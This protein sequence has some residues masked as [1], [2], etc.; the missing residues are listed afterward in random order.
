MR[1]FRAR[2]VFVDAAQTLV[3]PTG[4]PSGSNTQQTGIAGNMACARARAS[5]GQAGFTQGFEVGNDF[6]RM[7]NEVW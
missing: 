4:T 3:N 2:G 5:A 6:S 7:L 1:G